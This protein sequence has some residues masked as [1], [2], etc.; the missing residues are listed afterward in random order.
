MF[1][2]RGGPNDSRLPKHN[3]RRRNQKQ[4]TQP[5]V[6]KYAQEDAEAR[7]VRALV[8][9]G[10][11]DDNGSTMYSDQSEEETATI[12]AEE[13]PTVEP[14]T[15]SEASPP[16]PWRDE[17]RH[18][19]KRVKNVQESIQLSSNSISNPTTYNQNV[20]NAVTN[21]VNEWRSIVH[22]YD[23]VIMDHPE[24]TKETSLAVFMLIQLSLQSGPLA[25]AKP[26]YFKRCGG[27]VAKVVMVFLDTVI[28]M[29]DHMRFS[30]KQVDALSTWKSN[31]QKAAENDKPPSKSALKKQSKP[32][33]KS[34]LKKQSKR[35]TKK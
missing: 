29:I 11:E 4:A 9:D 24:E 33:S 30:D 8:D 28:E 6:N 16:E 5:A 2:G 32:P 21:S 22:H 15:P 14:E 18:L 19:R 13:T 31:A 35:N 7:V 23:E 25:G 34:A 26:G 20:L 3:A 17:M 27:E 1:R 10:Q 12:E